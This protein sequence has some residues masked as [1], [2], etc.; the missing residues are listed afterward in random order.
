VSQD[1]SKF[2]MVKSATTT[3]IVVVHGWFTEMR[4]RLTGQR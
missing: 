4:T 1:G 2:L 3:K